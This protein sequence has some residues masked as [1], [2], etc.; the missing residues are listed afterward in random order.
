MDDIQN[1]FFILLLV[2]L[3][4][5][6]AFFSMAETSFMSINRYRLRHKA[7]MKNRYA[8]RL[9]H[10][11][12]RPDRLLGA[13]LIGNTFA[14]ML[15][16]A[17]ATLIAVDYFGDKGALV[18]AVIMTFIVLIFAEI[19]PKTIAALYA[20]KV[21]RWLT[22]PISFAMRIMHPV[23]VGANAISNS[24][25]KLFRIPVHVQTTEPLTREEFRT[26]VHE[27]TGKISRQYQNMLLGILDL[28]HLSVD[29]VMQPSHE[30]NAIDIELPWE[31]I[32]EKLLK[33][34]T[35]AV[36]FYRGH[37]NHIIGV[38][39]AHD[40]QRLLLENIT[41]TKDVLAATLSDPYFV[42]E[43]TPLNIQLDQYQQHEGQP[44]FVVDEYGEIQGM[45]TVNDIL[46]EIVGDLSSSINGKRAEKQDDGSYLID[47]SYS[48]REFNRLSGWELPQR[49]ARTLNGLIIEYLE[50]L[51]NAGSALLIH[52][53]PI[54][55]VTVKDKRIKT[56]RIFPR[57][58]EKEIS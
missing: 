23:V 49:G 53:Y 15:T 46:E 5:L 20:D 52:D 48:V 18:S 26:V 57:L 1:L 45:L 13:I 3:I 27:T 51:P 29:D 44:A 25:L 58:H 31:T 32:K 42:P 55:I 11:L 34:N 47:G 19:T 9:L 33:L 10:L 16:S 37:I 7:K 28:S 39:Y 22:Y 56:A 38:L 6:S 17:I 4:L 54:E 8:V 21:A 30:M 40:L 2:F 41:F 35:D 14:N 36:P 43:G 12:R 24:I 50:A